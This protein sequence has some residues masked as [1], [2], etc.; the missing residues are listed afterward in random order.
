MPAK[1][2]QSPTPADAAPPAADRLRN[3][4]ATLTQRAPTDDAAPSAT[5]AE[6]CRLAAVSRNSLYRHHPAVLKALHQY[7]YERRADAQAA[8]QISAQLRSENA[9]L[10]QKLAKLAALVDH[11][12]GAY[13]ETRSLLERRDREL[14]ELRRSLQNPL[15]VAR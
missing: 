1:P 3:A 14:A 10:Q 4:L 6:L 9:L 8:T 7:Q 13:R 11:Y 2:E 15:A 12:Y 5:I